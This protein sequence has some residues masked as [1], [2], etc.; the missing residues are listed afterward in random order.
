MPG[1]RISELTEATSL[2]STDLIEISQD[3]GGGTYFSKKTQVGN[4]GPSLT[5]VT[6]ANAIHKDVSGEINSLTQKTAPIASDLLLIEDSENSNSK[7]KIS[8]S[9]LT[10]AI[11]SSYTGILPPS[12]TTTSTTYVQ[13]ANGSWTWSL[14]QGTYFVNS[15][16]EL[17][18]DGNRTISMRMTIDQ[19]DSTWTRSGSTITVNSV[20]H[21]LLTGHE[22][23]VTVSSN[24]ST[25]PLGDYT[26]TYIDQDN[27]SFTGVATGG[28]SGTLSYNFI[29]CENQTRQNAANISVN[30]GGFC[31]LTTLS[32]NR[33]FNLE[34]KT[35][36]GTVT[37]KYFKIVAL[38]IGN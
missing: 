32:G 25:I 31:I 14:A 10:S 34:W 17:S 16:G 38:K 27:F 5:G 9:S 35:T 33:T 12:Q 4:I 6:D 2:A 19:P 28:T 22:I 26:I 37:G 11:T 18:A 36:F 23:A 20:G 13:V 24:I 21:G 8:L 1:Y 29:A 30:Q 3:N 7:A 15:Y